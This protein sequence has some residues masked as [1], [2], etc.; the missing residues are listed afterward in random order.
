MFKRDEVFLPDSCFNKTKDDEYL[1]VLLERDPCAPETIRFWVSQRIKRGLN[2]SS[3]QKLLSALD[4][5]DRMEQSRC[6]PTEDV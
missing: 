1:F 4:V 3:D 6:K 2:L 5:A